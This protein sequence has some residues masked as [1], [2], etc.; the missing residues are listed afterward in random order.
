MF[1]AAMLSYMVVGTL[2]VAMAPQS[3]A[4]FADLTIPTTASCLRATRHT[5]YASVDLVLGSPPNLLN[6]LLRM[7]MIKANNDTAARLFSNRVAESDSVVCDGT[8]CVDTALVHPEGP[9]SPQVRSVV[10]FE[11]TNPTTE[12]LTFGTAAT[13]G[14]DG[15]FAL[16]RGFDYYLTATHLCWA[17]ASEAPCADSPGCDALAVEAVVVNERLQTTGAALVRASTT[18]TTPVA[19]AQTQ[20]VCDAATVALFPGAA[21]DEATWLGLAS[22]RAYETT[23]DNVE[24]RRVVVEVGTTC[25]ANYTAVAR[26]LSLYQLDCLSAYV[27]CDTTP[28]VPFRRVAMDQLRL[29]I[30]PAPGDTVRVFTSPDS[31]LG[32]LP[33]LEEDG[34]AM[35]LSLVKLGLMTLAAAVTWIRAAKSTSSLDRLF[36]HCVRMAHCH[37]LEAESVDEVVVLEDAAIGL[38]ALS[39]RVGVAIWRIV[40][41]LPDGQLRAPLSQV[42]ASVL[43]FVQWFIRYF[44]LERKCEAPLTKLGGST[45]L[46]DAT[47][48]V[49]M[50]FA[51]PP[52]MQTSL[53]KF[54]PTARLLTALLITTLTLQRCLFSSACCGLLYAV[55]SEDASKPIEFAAAARV[56]PGGAV[57]P[58]SPGR[59]DSAYVPYVIFG[60]VSWLL[61]TASVAI[62]MADVFCVPLAH[63]MSRSLA[64]GWGEIAM[65]LFAATAAAG[66]PTMMRTLQFIAQE[67]VGKQ[68]SEE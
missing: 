48:A 4:Q 6:L 38:V 42:V 8:D 29:H 5:N 49:L 66:M 7:D 47:C 64:G 15:E 51:E 31:R 21:A 58:S 44:V 14:L 61:Q 3:T 16:K 63:S 45:A 1:V 19:Q 20:G 54:D 43:S 36:M 2:C 24:D 56:G 67:P 26:A 27:S 46:V 57:L 35:G 50:G 30:P 12:S 11:Y 9:N 33:K 53:G 55:A 37:A 52:L 40:T 10:E 41:L 28:S 65:C 22:Q 39:T 23:P 32:S 17:P 68:T 60:L 13:M 62:L 59:F 25:A 34:H 18:H